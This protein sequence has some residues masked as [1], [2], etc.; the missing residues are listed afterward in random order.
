MRVA[1]LRR[2]FGGLCTV[3]AVLL[4][5]LPALPAAATAKA[6]RGAPPPVTCAGTPDQPMDLPSQPLLV[7]GKGAP[8]QPDLL[9][10]GPCKVDTAAKYYYGNVNIYNG[11][12]LDFEQPDTGSPDISIWASAIV[13]EANGTLE[14]GV[15]K[16]A[17]GTPRLID[18]QG[19]FL[20]I[21]LYGAN[22]SVDNNGNPVDPATTPGQGVLCKSTLTKDSDNNPV[23]C[24]IPPAMWQ[25]NGSSLLPGC[26]AALST[27]GSKRVAE[28]ADCLPGL[29]TA[30]KD[31][32]YQYGPLYGD[33]LCSNGKT[34]K[35]AGGK[36]LCGG[37]P[38]AG[39]VGYF[40]YKVLAVSYGGSLILHGYK[41]TPS[42]LGV[43][44]NPLASG[45]SW[46][47]LKGDI[48]PPD[49][50]LTLAGSPAD[51]WWLPSDGTRDQIV[52]TTTDYLPGHSEELTINQVQGG[53]VSFTPVPPPPPAF[54][55]LTIQ[56][57]H[58]GTKYPVG[59]QITDASARARL[60]AAG[61]D[62]NLIDNGAETRAAVALLTRSIRIVSEGDAAGET[63]EAA[64]NR[65][66]CPAN[67]DNLKTG[68]YYFGGHTVFRQGFKQ[69]QIQGVE[70]ADLGQGGKLGHYP[71]HFHMARQVPPGTIIK[72]SVVNESNTRWYVVHATQGVTFQRDVGWKSIGH[73]YYLEDGS[74]A[75]NNFYSDIGIF[76]RAAIDNKQNPR[77][78]PG[79]LAYNGPEDTFRF[80][81]R[82]DNE[83]PTVFWIPNGWNNF[84]GDMAAGAGA[85]GASYWL[86]P[87][88]N[89]DMPDV[90][91]AAN[92]DQLGHMNWADGG[93]DAAGNPIPGYA[94]LQA[95]T[96]AGF[97]GS[98]ALESFFS[99]YA[100]T[101]ME[102]FQT[103][104]N[105][106]GVCAGF[107]AA[108]APAASTPTVKEIQSFA[109]A[110]TG[111]NPP[112]LLTDPYY[113]HATGDKKTT[114]CPLAANQTAGLPTQYDCRPPPNG[115][116]ASPCADP[117]PLA[118]TDPNS[119]ELACAVTVLDHFTSSF[120][121]AEGNGS[122][123]WLRR[124]WFLVTNSVL[125]DVQQGGITFVTGGDVTRSSII[126]GYW[127]LLRDSILV[128][129]TQPQNQAHAFALDI[130]PFNQSTKL[131]CEPQTGSAIPSYCLSKDQGVSLPLSSFF[132]NERLENIYDGPSYRD[133]NAYL[134]VSVSNCAPGTYDQV[135]GTCI[136]GS[137]QTSGLLK[138][139]T[140]S[141]PNPCYLPNA[142]IAWKQPNGF[143]YPP[144]FHAEN[145]YFGNVDI[146]HFV[147]DP[148]FKAFDG[149][150]SPFTDPKSL[151]F[152]Q[153]GTYLTDAAAVN[154]VYCVPPGVNAAI[155][156]NSFSGI[157]RQT[158]LNDDDGTLTGLSN[159]LQ[160]TLMPPNALKQTISVN[161]DD[162]F[163]APVETP[164]CGSNI[165]KNVDPANACSS[166]V[167][168][169]PT[170]TAKTS[171]YDYVSTVVYHTPAG[172]IWDADCG[173]PQCYGVPLYRQLLAGDPGSTAKVRKVRGKL[174]RIRATQPSREWAHWI[175]N[176]CNT[177]RTTK[178][179]RWPFIRMSG[180]ALSTRETLTVNNGTYYL[181]TT[182]P[183]DVQRA[184]KFNTT[185][186]GT[187][188]NVFQPGDTY[189]VFFVYA[190]PSTRQKY[191]IYLGENATAADIKAIQMRLDTL[192]IQPTFGTAQP[193]LTTDTSQVST[194]GIVTV[195]VDFTQLKDGT[196][197]T[198]NFPGNGL[199][200]PRT[201]C[202]PSSGMPP[203]T[204][205]S[206]LS[207]TDPLV[208]A[209][210]HFKDQNKR[211]C[212]D[213]AVKDL[214]C[215]PK[216]CY[217]FSFTIPGSGFSA[218]ATLDNP[219]PNRPAPLPFP[220]DDKDKDQGSPTWLVELLGTPVAPDPS[221]QQCRY[222]KLPG[223]D[224]PV[225]DWV[226]VSV[227]K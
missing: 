204:C 35:A 28:G 74:E 163:T 227:A 75:N 42:L 104:A 30:A 158:E 81:Q 130:G 49:T 161:E 183:G 201:F 168:A 194:S 153:A 191:Q 117:T 87:V 140:P 173:N 18:K 96:R 73:G 213:W 119:P 40:G 222:P 95:R 83:F 78:V 93:V 216:G 98:T 126:T 169:A 99:N 195:T 84:E 147:I 80:P 43:D 6:R 196:L 72:D 199:C 100:T 89:S 111:P 218:D 129:H 31:Y 133:S 141:S 152:G 145:L 5:L 106:P 108:N 135:R 37:D 146:R 157:D 55:P 177:D 97:E 66:S 131:A 29:P 21:H 212:N 59:S 209:N 1:S 4:A 223:T 154:A 180:T 188:V 7:G 13:V 27:R 120:H 107:L 77:K 65:T 34:F 170:V 48:A 16:P 109:P 15:T 164:E 138:D 22:Q 44:E 45:N 101:T 69:I 210:S 41:G 166:P 39:E 68:C 123:I 46:M 160:P 207:D 136:Y 179:C 220:S 8:E 23:P 2:Q 86:V 193:W 82:S 198:A 150:A 76:A 148:L 118:P 51:R 50:S 12:V 155:Y 114:R 38:A 178:E 219:S 125:T 113:P 102:S 224:C 116:I 10:T 61:M 144:A 185:G 47:R 52:V 91:T 142:A 221:T 200:Q 20:T 33:G 57:F 19:G 110:P 205:D 122:A 149:S 187:S 182:V 92:T 176:G 127:G 175:A 63:Y 214:D 226:P 70:L 60:E 197:D 36:G 190:K 90:P 211:V 192:Q 206:A 32:F 156:F 3:A 151:D 208:L 115:K 217:G 62:K 189:F 143:F 137:Q 225:P 56:W 203:F 105:A 174:T 26:G 124:L 121:W 9:V 184:E 53:Q 172:G 17:Y 134:D 128:G 167:R 186:I 24:G 64:T 112:D 215:P 79:I 11:G 85:C 14:A 162:Y 25:S 71:V 181:D 139:P 202:Q 171:P 103:T 132:N 159:D 88:G 94:G 67:A 54:A 165:G 58:S